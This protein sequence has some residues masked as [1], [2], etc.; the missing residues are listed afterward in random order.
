MVLMEVQRTSKVR[1]HLIAQSFARQGLANPGPL[2]PDRR[3]GIIGDL[4]IPSEQN[5]L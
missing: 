2:R 3:F 5:K 1:L 4:A